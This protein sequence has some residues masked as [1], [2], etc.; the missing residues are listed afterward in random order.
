MK[1]WVLGLGGSSHDF[2]AALA[3]NG[4]FKVAIEEERLSRRK[5][6][7]AWWFENP[8]RR[9]VDYCLSSQSINITAVETIVTSDLIPKRVQFAYRDKGLLV[10]TSFVPCCIYLHA[11]TARRQGGD[12]CL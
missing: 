8:V 2:S 1:R 5:H 7:F 4:D 10:S 6:G 3:L 12:H 9:S 11:G